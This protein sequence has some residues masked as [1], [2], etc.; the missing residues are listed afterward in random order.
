[1]PDQDHHSCCHADHGLGRSPAS[2]TDITGGPRWRR[3]DGQVRRRID[4]EMG[5]RQATAICL[6]ELRAYASPMRVAPASGW[7]FIIELQPWSSSALAGGEVGET[8]ARVGF[9]RH[10]A[11]TAVWHPSCQRHRPENAIEPVIVCRQ[12]G[13]VDARSGEWAA[14]CGWGVGF[15]VIEEGYCFR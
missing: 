5:N 14:G 6:E 15:D 10:H 8:C 11:C 7:R 1:M 13:I 12:E 2:T 9:V 3:H 4:G